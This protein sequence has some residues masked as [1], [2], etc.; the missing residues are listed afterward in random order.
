L[1]DAFGL[2]ALQHRLPMMGVGKADLVYSS[3]I[4]FEASRA[5]PR[6]QVVGVTFF[7]QDPSFVLVVGFGAG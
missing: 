1:S 4:D 2:R 6:K 3:F 5:L 7:L